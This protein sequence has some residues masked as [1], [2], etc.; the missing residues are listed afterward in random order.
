MAKNETAAKPATTPESEP[1]SLNEFCIRLST[2]D[3]RDELIGGFEH[4][5]RVAGRMS[6][7]AE[8]YA[9]R[10]AAFLNQPA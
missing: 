2:M 1:L 4:S 10:Y 5:E 9:E 8:K 7:T 6:D 3:K